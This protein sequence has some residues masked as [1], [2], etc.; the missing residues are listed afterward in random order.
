MQIIPIQPLQNQTLQV[1]L[2]EQ[3]IAL[4][5]YQLAYGLFVDVYKD[6]ALVIGGVIA[7][8][9]NRIVR[10][11]YL[12]IIGD[13]TFIDTQAGP[14]DPGADPVYTGLGTR[15]QLAYLEAADLLDSGII[16]TSPE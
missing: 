8:N 10:D 13:F 6:N 15:Y 11:A 16:A 3:A 14:G 4:N 1:Q 5:I 9:L 12:G 7:Q 2:A